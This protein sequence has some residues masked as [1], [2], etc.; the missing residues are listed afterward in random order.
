MVMVEWE[1]SDCVWDGQPSQTMGNCRTNG[2]WGPGQGCRSGS[3]AVEA[4]GSQPSVSSPEDI[5]LG[6]FWPLG[7]LYSLGS[8][9]LLAGL[10]NCPAPGYS[11][12]GT[13]GLRRPV[14]LKCQAN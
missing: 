14:L 6:Y 13:G 2:R 10:W 8:C 9:T 7:A 12:K 4:K 11:R 3:P 5:F 1:A